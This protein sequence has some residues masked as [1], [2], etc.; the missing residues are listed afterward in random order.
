MYFRRIFL[1]YTCIIVILTQKQF[2]LSDRK[3]N[4]DSELKSWNIPLLKF[5]KQIITTR[6]GF[7]LTFGHNEC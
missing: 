4:F 2:L 6:K 3:Y 5:L 7:N 1:E